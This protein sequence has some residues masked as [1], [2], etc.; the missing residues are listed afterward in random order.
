[1]QNP[2]KY[3]LFALF[4]IFIFASSYFLVY[5][6]AFT[7]DI[8]LF[9][10]D[11]LIGVMPSMQNNNPLD[12]GMGMN[13][14]PPGNLASVSRTLAGTN[15]V[16]DSKEVNLSDGSTYALSADLVS[17]T[18]NGQQIR[19]YSYN[20]EFP[21]PTLRVKQGSTINVNFKN[22]LDVAT[23]V[24][25]HGIR[26]SN[27]YDGVPDVTQSIVKPGEIFTYT[28]N[29]PDAGVYWYHPHAEEDLQQELGLYG[30]II[31]DSPSASYYNPVNLEQ[32]LFL[33]DIL[34]NKNDVYPFYNKVT[35][36]AMMGRF[37]NTILVNGQE[38]FT[39]NLKKGDTVRFFAIDSANTRTLNVSI[40]NLSLKMI[41]S[42]GGKYEQEF[43][44]N[45]FIISPSERATFEAKFDNAGSY[46]IVSTT[47]L[48]TTILGKILVHGVSTDNDIS[49][50]SS[51]RANN[52]VISSINP[53]RQYFDKP[54]D[55][56][57]TLTS[58]AIG[59]MQGN[60]GMQMGGNPYDIEWQDPDFSQNSMSTNM[61]ISWV[62]KDKNTAKENLDINQAVAKN[63]TIKI[64]IEN[65]IGGVDSM[66]HPIHIH[67]ANFLVLTRNGVKNTNLVWK[68]TVLVKKGETVEILTYFPNSG[69]WMMHC[70]IS[71][72]L[73]SG[74]MS[75]F[76]VR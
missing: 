36:F 60:S 21:G 9:S 12:T 37:G 53:Y 68:D 5:Y 49:G 62:I 29:F 72:H 1:M 63:K 30:A 73:S 74:M 31:V 14:N 25:W 34:I 22:N 70:H 26:L 75:M 11:G 3:A 45:S 23:T 64:K 13:P 27:N 6:T 43:F 59:A 35:N 57:Y 54:N 32:I 28:L 52:D 65:P 20:G 19:M 76:N 8:G 2:I 55:F 50:F 44:S 56:N 38:Q 18:I 66:Q 10:Q 46:D 58:K 67:G 15:P 7:K 4:I 51:L 41:G 33:D 42:D 40:G 17:K 61:G 16:K 69:Q 39:L 24:H 71:E 48:G 47:P